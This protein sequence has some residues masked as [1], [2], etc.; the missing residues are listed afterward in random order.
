MS[1]KMQVC[2]MWN[3]GVDSGAALWR[4]WREMD[5][6]GLIE[7][8][9]LGLIVYGGIVIALVLMTRLIRSTSF[10]KV[11]KLERKILVV[12]VVL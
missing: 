5:L 8:K 3:W 11:A 9:S 10:A 7:W 6:V 2:V 1:R 12:E 4:E